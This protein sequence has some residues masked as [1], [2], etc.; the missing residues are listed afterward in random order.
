MNN[1]EVIVDEQDNPIG[2]KPWR[3]V[4]YAD[5]Y[6]VSALWLTDARTGEALIAQRKWTKKNDPGRWGPAVAGTIELN[7]TY[8]TNIAKE[9][10]E[11]IGLTGLSLTFGPKTY[12]D[13]GQHKFFCQWFLAS[14]DKGN[15]QLKLQED[16]VEGVKWVS[17]DWL[18]ADLAKNPRNYT[19]STPQYLHA[20]GYN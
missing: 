10:E 1:Y 11:E 4:Q 2:S 9:I 5:V 13:D 17:K 20:L 8:E 3:D 15:I 16:E 6:R 19:P 14:V 12:T 18:L 7:E